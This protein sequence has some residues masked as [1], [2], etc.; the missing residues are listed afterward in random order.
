[1]RDQWP[2]TFW[3]VPFLRSSCVVPFE[4]PVSGKKGGGELGGVLMFHKVPKLQ[5]DSKAL[6]HS[7]TA[8]GIQYSILQSE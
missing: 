4:N 5:P 2:G 8:K 1:V 6:K 7:L 3:N